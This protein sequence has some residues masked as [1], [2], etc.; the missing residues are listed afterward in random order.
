[1]LNHFLA[2]SLA[3]PSLWRYL[4]IRFNAL[5][6]IKSLA[7][8]SLSILIWVLALLVR[9]N[10][11]PIPVTDQPLGLVVQWPAEALFLI[12]F[13][14]ILVVVLGIVI[15]VLG[16]PQTLSSKLLTFDDLPKEVKVW[17]E[18]NIEE[19]LQEGNKLQGLIE[20][21][22][23]RLG[24][25]NKEVALSRNRIRLLEEL[26]REAQAHIHLRNMAIDHRLHIERGINEQLE[27][28]N[29]RTFL[30]QDRLRI[31]RGEFPTT[32]YNH[33]APKPGPEFNSR[34]QLLEDRS[35]SQNHN[36]A[37]ARFSPKRPA[38]QTLGSSS[39]VG[40]V[41][42]PGV[43]TGISAL[44]YT[45]RHQLTRHRAEVESLAFSPDGTMLVS[46]SRDG[47]IKLWDTHSGDLIH[48]FKKTGAWSIAFSQMGDKLAAGYESGMVEVWQARKWADSTT[49]KAH[50]DTVTSLAF[51]PNDGRIATASSD[52]TVKLW[53]SHTTVLAKTIT[54]HS[55]DVSSVVFS[56]KGGY[57]ASASF[58]KTIRLWKKNEWLHS[59]QSGGH[60]LE[61]HQGE[62]HSLS[63]SR[64]GKWLASASLDRTIRLW[65]TSTGQQEDLLEGHDDG[66]T[67]VA[68]SPKGRLLAS[69]SSDKTVKLWN[70]ALHEPAKTYTDHAATVHSVAFSQ[71]GQWLASASADK[72]VIIYQANDRD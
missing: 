57:L 25:Q 17:L 45:K 7:I 2:P 1:M 8:H 9:V 19:L 33:N 44:S 30:K 52:K 23:C 43:E 47:T 35:A 18:K 39:D 29:W 28:E 72:T 16:T 15:V 38:R 51:S 70:I 66:V 42:E 10:G 54:A 48:E 55:E 60:I 5:R 69:A 3:P 58:D 26:R 31:E 41:V 14:L 22:F 13:L 21:L 56:P 34:G 37:K 65:D 6:A 11:N 71:N 40:V 53:N 68:F 64:D 59:M 20:A 46:T 61:G 50:S 62:I 27:I 49:F 36:F 67:S 32:A 63:F 12:V 4:R 24:M